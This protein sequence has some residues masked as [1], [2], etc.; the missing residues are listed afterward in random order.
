MSKVLIFTDGLNFARAI[1][2]CE[3]FA[4]RANISFGI[5]TFLAN[6]MGGYSSD[7][8]EYQPLSIVVKM[9]ECNGRPVA[10]ISDEPE[11]AMCEDEQFLSSLKQSF[12][13]L[14]QHC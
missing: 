3:Y 8:I 4:G 9:A 7:G 11:K 10:K 1:E 2:I 6:D 5:G 14:P 13:L 12:G